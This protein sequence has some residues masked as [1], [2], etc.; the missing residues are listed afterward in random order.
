MA[1]QPIRP[2]QPCLGFLMAIPNITVNPPPFVKSHVIE[3]RSPARFIPLNRWVGPSEAKRFTMHSDGSLFGRGNCFFQRGS[4]AL[5][6]LLRAPMLVTLRSYWR[7]TCLYVS[8]F[9]V[10][11]W[12]WVALI[13]Q[14]ISDGALERARGIES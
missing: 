6:R 3:L 2:S 4:A 11:P 12:T 9:A 8:V 1:L 14:G 13:S 7:H 10:L 5:C